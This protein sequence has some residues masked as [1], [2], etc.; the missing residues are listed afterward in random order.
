MDLQPTTVCA[1][2]LGA[3]PTPFPD[4]ALPLLIPMSSLETWR[5]HILDLTLNPDSDDSV[6][7]HQLNF[8]VLS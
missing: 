4:S 1:V 5:L 3:D 8:T 7:L 6:V 2:R